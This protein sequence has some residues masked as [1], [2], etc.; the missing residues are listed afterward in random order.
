MV[1]RRPVTELSCPG[2]FRELSI[3]VLIGAAL[4]VATVGIMW[5]LGYYRVTQANTWTVAVVLLANDGAGAFVEE[6][7]LRASSSGL[8]RKGWARG[9]LSQSPPCC[10]RCCSWRAPMPPWPAL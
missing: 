3:G 5:M 2:A 6:I 8:R 4:A 1:E 9:W 10:S 7:I